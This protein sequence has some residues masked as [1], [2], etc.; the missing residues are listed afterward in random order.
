[1]A[2][3]P[4]ASQSASISISSDASSIPMLAATIRIVVSWQ[5]ASAPSSRSPEQGTSP[6]PPTAG[7]A[8][9]RQLMSGVETPTAVQWSGSPRSAWAL[10]TLNRI[11]AACGSSL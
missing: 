11:W 4:R 10:R 7:C 9:D 8:P 5:A 2:S 1:M 6:V 3:V